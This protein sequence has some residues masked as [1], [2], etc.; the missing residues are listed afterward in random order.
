[1]ESWL[2]LGNV[3][4]WVVSFGGVVEVMGSEIEGKEHIFFL[5]FNF[6]GISETDQP[7]ISQVE[8]CATKNQH[9]FKEVSTELKFG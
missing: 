7:Q 6:M 5:F 8:G 4:S 3:G 2:W 1:M 9:E